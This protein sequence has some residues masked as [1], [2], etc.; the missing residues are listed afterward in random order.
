MVHCFIC[1]VHYA[2]LAQLDYNPC[3]IEVA[4]YMHLASLSLSLSFFF[5][6]SFFPFHSPTPSLQQHQRFTV[7]GFVEFFFFFS[8][9]LSLG[10]TVL[11]A[12]VCLSAIMS[13]ADIASTNDVTSTAAASETSGSFAT[14]AASHVTHA[15]TTDAIV[16]ECIKQGFY[17][18]P[19]CNEKLYLHN[20]GFDSIAP[21]AFEP[22]T[23]VKV[24]WLEGNG[25]S[26]LPCG[27][28]YVQVQPPIRADPFADVAEG[29]KDN[30]DAAEVKQQSEHH[31]D[32]S[33]LGTLEPS[34]AAPPRSLP[35]PADIPPEKRDAFSS[36]Y[37]TVRQLYLHNNLFR[38]MPDLSRFQRL[39]SVN[40]SGNFFSAIV[41]HCVHW[42]RK[43]TTEASEAFP[44]T[45]EET[46]ESKNVAL[47]PSADDAA[48][49]RSAQ[50]EQYRRMAD[51]H[52][53]LCEHC[54]L[55]EREEEET[56]AVDRRNTSSQTHLATTAAAAASA[57]A[58]TAD[59][60]IAATRPYVPRQPSVPDPEYRNPCSSL[61]NLNVAGNRLETFED[62]LGLLSYKALTV[63]DL[64]H[65]SIQDGEALLL[66]LERLRRLQSLK[67]SGNPLVRTLPRY[68]KRVLSRCKQL[69]YLDDRPVF[70]E[71]RRLVTAWARAGDDGE[72]KE[73]CLIRQ[74][75]EAAE[76][77]RLDDFRRLIARHNDA[78]DGEAP[79]ADYVRAVTTAAALSA[80]ADTAPAITTT[81]TT[82]ESA[83]RSHRF[84]RQSHRCA[85]ESRRPS[86]DPDN[87]P[88]S[89]ESDDDDDDGSTDMSA[90]AATVGGDG[91]RIAM[92]VQENTN[93]PA[94]RGASREGPT[95]VLSS[96][97]RIAEEEPPAHKGSGDEDSDGDIFV[98]GV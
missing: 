30:K 10:K 23:D 17:R 26:S 92:R 54:P 74:E 63:L 6:H 47:V 18:N 85:P 82:R 62:C 21:T 61:R 65:N 88:T 87:S 45:G 95:R 27:A 7:L 43:K 11:L 90:G 94:R 59:V 60:P 9:S 49:R 22:Y 25:F 68:R 41:P 24:L 44:P 56:P 46:E 89:S 97:Q 2:F 19:I 12:F 42:D 34:S 29:K 76:K 57:T 35:L 81:I 53:I 69:L 91:D 31:V 20:R 3:E 50:L 51:E 72:E 4:A 55:P 79:H 96:N 33:R 93:K 39:D 36:L 1:D 66:I 75:K 80:A 40:L 28:A 16:R 58:T 14:D 32:P 98:P 5:L 37:P 52:A 83:G 86:S 48:A 71:E 70:D 78:A 77:K 38:V 73:R 13:S 64:S 84:L 67:L 8:L 15:L